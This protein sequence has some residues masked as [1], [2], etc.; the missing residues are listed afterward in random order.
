VAYL[1][2]TGDF[3]E[4]RARGETKDFQEIKGKKRE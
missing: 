3:F 4:E 1:R 2:C